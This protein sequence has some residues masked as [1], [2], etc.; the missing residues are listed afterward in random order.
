M[1]AAS[2]VLDA[3]VLIRAAVTKEP[4]A[5]EWV[6]SI[7]SGQID[8]HVPELAYAETVH[9]LVRYV[10][11]GLLSV[12]VAREI[13]EGVVSLP[14]ESHAHGRLATASLALA[15]ERDLSAYDATYA[16]LAEALDATLVTADRRLAAA[17]RT[18]ELIV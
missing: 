1:T 2:A 11:A 17:V 7:E 13:L 12:A 15:L 6:R 3:S 16:V 4:E 9:G 18:A 5:A 14:L 8:G 10:R